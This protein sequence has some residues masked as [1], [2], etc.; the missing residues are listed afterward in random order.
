MQC[1]RYSAPMLDFLAKIVG[2]DRAV[3]VYVFL[4]RW[5]LGIGLVSLFLIG[6]GALLILNSADRHEHLEYVTAEVL[7]VSP[8][9]SNTQM[10]VMVQLRLPD[11]QTLQ[12]TE[13]EGAISGSLS[14]TACVEARR[15]KADGSLSHRLRLPHRCGL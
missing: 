8:L 5:G 14:D 7:D 3:T 1:A 15:L 12:L 6:M 2:P 11:G 10:G 13:V 4:S 9:A